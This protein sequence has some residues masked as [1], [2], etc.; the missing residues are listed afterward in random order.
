M[1]STG[2]IRTLSVL[3]PAAALS[4]SALAEATITSNGTELTYDV[5]KNETHILSAAFPA[6]ASTIVKTGEGTLEVTAANSGRTGLVIDIRK[7]VVK[8]TVNER[9]FG[10]GETVKVASG[11]SLWY[12]GKPGNLWTTIFGT[13]EIAGDGPDHKGA[14]YY[15]GSGGSDIMITTLKV[16][17][18]AT[19]GGTGRFGARITDLNGQTLT[20]AIT[21]ASN[22]YVFRYFDW[23]AATKILNPGNIVQMSA[24][25]IVQAPTDVVFKDVDPE[26]NTWTFATAGKLNLLVDDAV[27][28]WAVRAVGSPTFQFSGAAAALDGP[29]VGV[30][31]TP[32]TLTVTTEKTSA[33]T[34]TVNADI[35]NVNLVVAKANLSIKAKDA[36]LAFS[37]ASLNGGELTVEGGSLRLRTLT[38]GL[39]LDGGALTVEGGGLFYGGSEY[40]IMRF[41]KG[42]H[43]R[44]SNAGDLPFVGLA[45]CGNDAFATD[46]KISTVEISG[47]TCLHAERTSAPVPGLFVGSYISDPSCGTIKGGWGTLAI[48]NGAIVTN[49][50]VIGESGADGNHRS[51][52]ALY[53]SDASLYAK[54]ARATSAGTKSAG[55]GAICASNANLVVAGGMTIGSGEGAV[56]HYVQ[57]GGKGCHNQS[58]CTLGGASANFYLGAGAYF[59]MQ[60]TFSDP[61]GVSVFNFA[62]ASDTATSGESVLTC[63]NN[64]TCCVQ[65]AYTAAK[66]NRTTQINLNNGGCFIGRQIWY[67]STHARAENTT[68][69]MSFN[70]GVLDYQSTWVTDAD[71]LKDAPDRMVVHSGGV[72]I[73][74]AA[75]SSL[76]SHGA[77]VRPRGKS[78]KSI[79]PPTDADYLAATNIGPA[80]I[81]FEGAGEGMTA[82]IAFNDRTGSLGNVIL[83][84]PGEGCDATTRAYAV[85]PQYPDRRFECGLELEEEVGGDLVKFGAG[86][87]TL[88]ST[89]TYAGATVVRGGQLT[90]GSDWAIPS[91][92]TVRLEG[93]KLYMNFKA[94]WLKS[95]EGTGGTLSGIS[96]SYINVE[97]LSTKGFNGATFESTSQLFVVGAWTVDADDLIA[98]KAAGKVANYAAR[99]QFRPGSTIAFTGVEKL[100]PALS[101]Y[102]I[103]AFEGGSRTGLPELV[104]EPLPGRWRFKVKDGVLCLSHGK[105][106]SV[107][108]R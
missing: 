34:L 22:P 98:N 84:S 91:N 64:A 37:Q 68:Y 69:R 18:G 39:V 54:K 45:D 36:N 72:S 2:I 76:L 62:S 15:T 80:R 71:V 26:K 4:G 35:T 52:G 63:D 100:D 21:S 75:N 105:G 103:C 102:P 17:E 96:G 31:E 97:H 93:G 40:G 33:Q 5:P 82:F 59:D 48:R 83:T 58:A 55:Y 104:G 94:A 88:D 57:L 90:V 41:N 6:T 29:V 74:V 7:G 60:R 56:G 92:T 95:L 106:F 42:A 49:S 77:F 3:L 9:V 8:A 51:V 16:M 78:V 12:T 24:Y 86:S 66:A 23:I 87:L 28:P 11:A 43:V 20:N 38:G 53:L 47:T 50:V 67:S 13:V 65:R 108:I 89:N 81:V 101:P 14:F 44:L 99:V 19:V 61:N 30:G 107:I 25:A 85:I 1:K 73:G 79:T 27:F 10:S 46:G 32:P 70:G